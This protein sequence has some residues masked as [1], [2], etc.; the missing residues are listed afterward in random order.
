[1]YR[2]PE[3]TAAGLRPA[4]YRYWAIMTLRGMPCASS[5]PSRHTI[6]SAGITPSEQGPP[7]HGF[8]TSGGRAA[9]PFKKRGLAN[10]SKDTESSGC[11]DLGAGAGRAWQTM[12][13][14]SK[15]G[16]HLTQETRVGKCD[17]GHL[18]QYLAGPT[19]L[20][21]L[22]SLLRWNRPC[23]TPPG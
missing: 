2:C 19:F 12:L 18:E 5:V 4:V 7:E 15:G 8:K 17:E 3:A 11:Q 16:R 23:T 20:N 10:V 6:R 22:A 9:M 13:K 1:V 14:T 21:Q